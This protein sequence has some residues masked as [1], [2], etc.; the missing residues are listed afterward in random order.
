MK[1]DEALCLDDVLLVPQYSDIKSRKEVDLTSIL[2]ERLNI[3]LSLPIISSPMDTITESEMVRAMSIGGGLGIIHRYNTIEEQIQIVKAIRRSYITSPIG[4]AIGVTKDYWERAG[5]LFE[6][7]V[8]IIC[9]D[10]AHGHHDSVEK[11]IKTIRDSYI[12]NKI[13]IMAGNVAT[14][15]AFIA[16]EEWGA[17]SIRVG[18]G[19]GSICSTRLNT[20]HGVPNLTSLYNCVQ[21]ANKA[22][23]ILDGGIKNAGDIVKAIAL[24]ADF[25]MVGSLLAG[26]FETPGN[27]II[28]EDKSYKEYR[29]MAS[30]QARE[31]ND[32]NYSIEGIS[33]LIPIKDSV[34]SILT[35]L[36]QNIKSGLSYSGARNIKELQQNAKFVRQ[37]SLGQR[38]SDTHILFRK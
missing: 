4:A 6:S 14:P 37:T 28:K 3:T 2:D 26:S 25:V 10:V 32:K 18:I 7:S 1:F 33:T 5:V 21:V 20:G 35:N 22:K 8:D 30:F 38:E 24:G 16:L 31:S 34:G 23:V 36:E 29:G 19:G 15:E 17:N 11:A 9:I 27:I 13:H 12:G